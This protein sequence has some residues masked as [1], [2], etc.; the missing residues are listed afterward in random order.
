MSPCSPRRL[1]PP[2]SPQPGG[3]LPAVGRP[4]VS[5]N[6][7]RLS[8]EKRF[9]ACGNHLCE[10]GTIHRGDCASQRL[11]LGRGLGGWRRPGGGDGGEATG[12]F[13]PARARLARSF[14][15]PDPA[16][17]PVLGEPRSCH[18]NQLPGL[19]AGRTGER[20]G[21]SAI[22]CPGE[23]ATGPVTENKPSRGPSG[24]SCCPSPAASCSSFFGTA[25]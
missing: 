10:N 13:S 18:P 1:L 16:L 14:P 6:K 21:W 2:S 25:Q 8:G 19:A 5:R 7:R 23:H 11:C 24:Q 3:S 4:L 20:R 9:S 22:G 15:L 12:C 17:R